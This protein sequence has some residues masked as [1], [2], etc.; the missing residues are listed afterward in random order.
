[1][2][3]IGLAVVNFD[4]NQHAVNENLRVGH[5]WEAIPAGAD[6]RIGERLRVVVDR[7]A[8]HARGVEL[9]Q[10]MLA[11][12]LGGDRLDALDERRAVA[13]AQ[14]VVR[15]GRVGAHFGMPEHLAEPLEQPIGPGRRA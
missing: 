14:R 1:M 3:T 5:L 6:L 2:P 10:P 11:R 13:D 15:E 9:R 7:S 8:R 12:L 4:N